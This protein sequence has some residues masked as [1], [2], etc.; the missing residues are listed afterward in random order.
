MPDN[1]KGRSYENGFKNLKDLAYG[2]DEYDCCVENVMNIMPFTDDVNATNILDLKGGGRNDGLISWLGTFCAKGVPVEK[3][4]PF[5]RVLAAITELDTHEIQTTVL[6]SLEKYE[7]RDASVYETGD[8]D[9]INSIAGEDYYSTMM[10]L[11]D[12]IKVN[13]I[14]GFDEA[15]GTG[16]FKYGTENI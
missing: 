4:K 2:W 1:Y 11:V 10:K 13:K 16:F 8:V 5:V 7:K 14:A 12:Y 15:T 3:I 9:K 6:S